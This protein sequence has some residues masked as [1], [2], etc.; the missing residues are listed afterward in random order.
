MSTSERQVVAVT[1]VTSGIGRGIAEAFAGTGAAVFG[2]GRRVDK[3]TEVEAA[4]RAAGHDFTFVQS[5]VQRV[6]DCVAFVDAAA[7]RHGHVDVFVNNAGTVGPDPAAGWDEIDEEIWDTVVDTNMKGTFF[8]TQA[9]LRVMAAR[10]RGVI[11]NIGSGAGEILAPEMPQ[12]RAS[13]AGVMFM[14]RAIALAAV[15]L[16]VRLHTIVMYRVASEAGDRVLASRLVGV[17]TEEADWIREETA[18]TGVT[19]DE[20]GAAMVKLVK[21]PSL[22]VGPNFVVR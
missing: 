4:L 9:A 2:S 18:A 14:S 13:K 22:L 21:Y 5:D 12:Y 15:A 3:G 6:G 19:A 8:S 7:A 11:I 10:G 20:V 16:G 17:D 1:G